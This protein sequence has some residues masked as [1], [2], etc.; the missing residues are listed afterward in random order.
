MA[1]KSSRIKSDQLGTLTYRTN[2]SDWIEAISTF[3]TYYTHLSSYYT[4]SLRVGNQV[5]SGQ[6]PM[7][8]LTALLCTMETEL[9]KLMQD[10]SQ[11]DSCKQAYTREDFKKLAVH[12]QILNQL[13]ERAQAMMALTRYTPS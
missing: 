4:K 3:Q 2:L 11:L 7:D 5:A 8:Q 9:T 1:R 6:C 12:T 10:L 13:N